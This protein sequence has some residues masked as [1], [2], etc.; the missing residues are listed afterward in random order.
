MYFDEAGKVNTD[1]TLRLAKERAEELGIK[2][3]VLASSSGYTAQKAL[4]VFQNTDY[5]LVL[6]GIE[7]AR[8]PSDVLTLLKERGVPVLFSGIYYDRDRAD[9]SNVVSYSYSKL[10]WN[11]FYKFSEGMKVVMELGMIVA[12]KDLVSE[13]EEVIAIAGTGHKGGF[14]ETGG[15]ADTAVVIVPRKS[16]DFNTLPELKA[17]RRDIREIIC[18]PR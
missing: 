9:S 16:D 10:M 2:T 6:V 18:K 14:K 13:N 11:A 5:N 1:A 8:F 3:I 15:G 7:V 12:E 4:E 17:E